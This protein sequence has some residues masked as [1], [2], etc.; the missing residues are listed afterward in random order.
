MSFACAAW[1]AVVRAHLEERQYEADDGIAP[2][3]A[4]KHLV[5]APLAEK[6]LDDGDELPRAGHRVEVCVDNVACGE[7]VG[8]VDGDVDIDAACASEYSRAACTCAFVM[9]DLDIPSSVTNLMMGTFALGM[10]ATWSAIF[11]RR[12]VCASMPRNTFMLRAGVWSMLTTRSMSLRVS[13][14]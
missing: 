5:Q 11:A 13:H 10:I 1:R 3:S 9:A 6:R 12:I 14:Q 7:T 2:E 8:L 4:S